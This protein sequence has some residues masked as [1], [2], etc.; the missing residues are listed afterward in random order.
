[1]VDLYLLRNMPYAARIS[2]VSTYIM[3]TEY[4]YDADQHL[5]SAGA[6]IRT[7]NLAKDILAYLNSSN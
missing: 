3:E 7:E 5:N 1:M 2:S 4:F 6:V